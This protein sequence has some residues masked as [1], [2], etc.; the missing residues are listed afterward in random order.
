MRMEIANLIRDG[1]DIVSL[2]DDH[3]AQV[4]VKAAQA[5]LAVLDAKSQLRQALADIQGAVKAKPK[6]TPAPKFTPKP[7]KTNGKATVRL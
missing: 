5:Q 1:I 4:W 6:A 7:S 2:C 3:D